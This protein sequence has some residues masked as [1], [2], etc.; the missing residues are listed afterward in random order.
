[1]HGSKLKAT[2]SLNVATLGLL[3][4]SH[5][6][7]PP[8]LQFATLRCSVEVPC[9]C[10]REYFYDSIMTDTVAA[11]IQ[12]TAEQLGVQARYVCALLISSHRFRLLGL[13]SWSSCMA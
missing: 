1:M 2:S 6:L 12:V 3:V 4:I 5:D 8:C 13:R 9:I 11:P 10:A 7:T